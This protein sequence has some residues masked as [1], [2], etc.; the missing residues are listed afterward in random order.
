LAAITVLAAFLR[1]YRI[2]SLPPS[3]GYDQATYGLDVLDI[4]DGARPIFLPTNFGREALFSYLVTLTYLIIGDVAAAVYVTSAVAGVLAIPAT[5]L[6]AEELFAAGE[7][8]K[9]D[10][11][12]RWGGLVA[13][14]ALALSR[15]HLSWSRL[16]MRA[17]LVPLLA[18]LT[19]WLLWRGLRTGRLWAFVGCGLSLGVSL[20]TYQAARALPLLVLLGYAYHAGSRRR[21]TRRDALNLALIALI[22]LIVFAPLG[23]YFLTHPGSFGL[24][25]GQAVVVDASGGLVD[26]LRILRDQGVNAFLALF[27]HGDEDARVN[28]PDWPI[29]DPFA[30]AA[31]LLGLVICLARL[32]RPAYLL[33]L[34]WLAGLSAPAILAQYGPVT[35]RAIGATPAVAMLVAV[36]CL[37]TWEGFAR[38]T[39]R[40]FPMRARGLS[41]ALALL[42]GAG[43]LYSGVQAY[44][45][46]FYVW[47]SDV[48]MFTHFETGKSAIGRYIKDRPPEERIYLS[49]V[50]VDHHIVALNSMRRPGVRSYIGRFCFVA[51][52]G[53]PTETTYVIVPAEDKNSLPLLKAYLPQGRIADE[54]PLHYDLPYFLAY[55]V[56]AGTRAQIVPGHVREVEWVEGDSGLRLRLL[57]YD[58]DK[59]TFEPGETLDLTLYYGIA[60]KAEADRLAGDYTVFVHLLGPFNA[61]TGGPLWAQ[62]DSEPCRRSY[63]TSAWRPNE[64]VVDRYAMAIPPDAPPG[65]YEIEVGFYC[66]DTLVRL[67]VL[68]AAGQA[69]GDHLILTT[70]SVTEG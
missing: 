45:H 26:N 27:V 43:F 21:F 42:L 22:A 39:G 47:A 23:I 12:A 50:P 70:V 59:R 24:R 49:P 31:L 25:I 63:R 29:L 33:L 61:A 56:P 62:D 51:V 8:T 52:D 44:R 11:L 55:R 35:K 53:A 36:G 57:G 10:A 13:A 40:R 58:L 32:K 14:L 41:A 4:L 15:W 66:W 9:E 5:Y 18:A 48:N 1:L 65:E 20:H 68:D 7:S 2:D 6:A 3:D 37:V 38:W 28:A 64:I 16:G 67:P 69:A 46:Y 30:S 34:T 54:G 19:V 17:I 60:G